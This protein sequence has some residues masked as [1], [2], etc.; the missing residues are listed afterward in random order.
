MGYLYLVSIP[1]GGVERTEPLIETAGGRR[2]INLDFDAGGTLGSQRRFHQDDCTGSDCMSFSP[3]NDATPGEPTTAGPQLSRPGY[4]D[5]LVAA[6]RKGHLSVEPVQAS[7]RYVVTDGHVMFV[8]QEENHATALALSGLPAP[9]GTT[10]G[11]YT[12]R[13]LAPGDP[14]TFIWVSAWAIGGNRVTPGP[15]IIR[16][17]ARA[18][19]DSGY[20]DVSRAIR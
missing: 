7:G 15:D 5:S 6:Q 4:P 13:Q 8:T 12:A 10:V 19:L 14:W 17:A 2:L 11:I 18:F 9:S 20:G 16:A 1:P 3:D